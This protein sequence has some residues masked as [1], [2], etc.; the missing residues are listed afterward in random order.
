MNFGRDVIFTDE[1][2]IDGS[3]VV[4]ELEKAF[5]THLVNRNRIQELYDV[6]R[7]KTAVLNKTKTVREEINNIVSENRAN[8]FV[9]FYKGYVLG[10]PIQYIRRENSRDE[11]DDD[12][13]AQNI[14]ALNS[15]MSDA[16]K[17]ACDIDMFEWQLICGVSYRLVVS[18]NQMPFGIFSLDPRNAFVVYA[19]T[20]YKQPLMA[21]TYITK[22]DSLEP[23]FSVYTATEYFE[24]Y[25]G[26][27][28]S[29]A[30][31]YLG[32]IPIVEY[33]LNN[34]RQGIIELVISL[35]D[36]INTIDSNRVDD[37]VQ[38]VNSFLALIGGDID[39][40]T[41][42]KLNRFKM[43]CMPSGVDAKYLSAPLTQGDIQTL[44]D[45][46]YKAALTICGIPN[47]NGGTSTSDTGSA[48]IM[49]DGWQD[50]ERR[51]KSME[52]MFKK[53][54]KGFLSIA[55]RILR[56]TEHIT[57]DLKDIEIHFTRR[58]YENIASKSQVLISMLNCD[59]IADELAF[60]SCGMF[61]DPESA[62]LQSKA[63]YENNITGNQMSNVQEKTN[64]LTGDSGNKVSQV[65]ENSLSEQQRE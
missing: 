20:V 9:N 46:L 38:F 58:N 54:E 4:R 59:K 30:P 53:S 55:L 63:E 44:K 61:A 33:P 64:G 23:Y 39:E 5:T 15:V 13:T 11:K 31:H 37:V 2:I 49:R 35:L 19:N 28:V 12:R 62:Y 56:N 16:D 45:D 6:Y 65:Q 10:E 25:N 51:A 22:T 27:I 29:Y 40:E 43:L 3:N 26:K 48:V 17:S 24:V 21:V 50:A 32:D 47:R 14:N 42:E 60:S 8:E 41:Y 18:T 52:T 36:A 1:K 57:L 34:S 7:N